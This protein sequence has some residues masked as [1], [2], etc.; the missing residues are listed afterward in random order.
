MIEATINRH[1][2]EQVVRI[3]R[4][5]YERCVEGCGQTPAPEDY[6]IAIEHWLRFGQTPTEAIAELEGMP[7]D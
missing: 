2:I 3:V 6:R 7:N 1:D 4:L 5:E